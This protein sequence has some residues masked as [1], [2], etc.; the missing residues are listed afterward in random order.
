[1]RNMI[2]LLAI[3]VAAS[4]LAACEP[5]AN[6]TSGPVNAANSGN[7][8]AKSVDMAAIEAD[9]KKLVSDTAA[10]MSKND[11][12]AF[13]KM[14]TD[15]YM[16]ISPDGRMST[17]ADR[18]TSLRSGDS[19]YESVAYDDVVVRPNPHGTGA[20]VTARATVKGVNMGN[21]VDGQFRIT[22]I[23]RKTDDGWK[24]AHGHA[25]AIAAS[26]S[27]SNANTANSSA[28]STAANTAGS[29]R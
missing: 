23:W 7:S 29:N 26:S 2:C 5:A 9:V 25:T 1:M 3:L 21:K 10:A 11:V 15:N 28:T 6:S 27:S 17:K 8:S 19:K 16:F 13:E 14:T 24:M 4:F 18:A 20:I 12:A 22:Q